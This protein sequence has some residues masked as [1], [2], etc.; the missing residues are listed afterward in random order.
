MRRATSTTR[1]ES[2]KGWLALPDLR[3]ELRR[4][5]SRVD[6]GE[7]DGR[8]APLRGASARIVRMERDGRVRYL[9]H[10]ARP[11]ELPESFALTEA[12]H[13]VAVLAASGATAA[14][15]AAIRGTATG[16]VKMQLKHI[17]ARLQVA[18]RVEL[19]RALKL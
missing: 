12:E 10:L 17:Y 9:V 2:A 11:P 5:V 8:D 13:D 3:E 18:T 16:T 14:E 7:L 4:V 6:R 15:I 19:A 1:A